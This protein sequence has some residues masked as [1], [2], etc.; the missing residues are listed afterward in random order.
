MRS[1]PIRS[2]NE[3][4]VFIHAHAIVYEASSAQDPLLRLQRLFI[5]ATN[6]GYTFHP[7]LGDALDDALPL[8]S[9]VVQQFIPI[10][11]SYLALGQSQFRIRHFGICSFLDVYMYVVTSGLS[12][13]CLI[14]P[15]HRT[16]FRLVLSDDPT[17]LAL[18]GEPYHPPKKLL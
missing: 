8:S 13:V 12:A 11:V 5:S 18:E 16:G 2:S 14:P 17:P 7:M 4:G 10:S 3:L 9:I 6:H 15:N 1:S